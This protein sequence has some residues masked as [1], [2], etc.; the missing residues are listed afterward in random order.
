MAVEGPVEVMSRAH[1]VVDTASIFST[2]TRNAHL[3]AAS[4]M[5]LVVGLP[6]P[7]P[8]LVSMRIKDRVVARLRRLQRRG[9]LEAVRRAPR[10]RRGR[11]S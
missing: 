11:R 4:S 7:W 6:A 9:E 10:G 5:S 3:S 8:A 1:L 2:L